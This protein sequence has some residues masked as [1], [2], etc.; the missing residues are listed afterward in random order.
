MGRNQDQCIGVTKW[1]LSKGRGQGDV[2]NQEVS[3]MELGQVIGVDSFRVPDLIRLDCP[4]IL[5]MVVFTL[6]VPVFQ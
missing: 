5:S 2:L 3:M 4:S 1:V 6:C